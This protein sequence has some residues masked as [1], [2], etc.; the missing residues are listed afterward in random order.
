ME[1][2]WLLGTILII[3]GVTFLFLRFF[4]KSHPKKS[5]RKRIRTQGSN[6]AVIDDGGA[7]IA[8]SDSG[9]HAGEHGCGE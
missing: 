3:G 8:T 4:D 5:K 1:I 2:V 7:H 6:F 9:H